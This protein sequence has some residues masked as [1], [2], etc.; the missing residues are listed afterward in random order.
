MV[1]E[2]ASPFLVFDGLDLSIYESLGSIEGELE[3]VDVEDGVYEAFDSIGRV[4][5]LKATGVKRGKFTV[6]I[7]KTHVDTVEATPTGAGRLYDL[8]R[9]HLREIGQAMPHGASL[10]HLVAKC[11]SVHEQRR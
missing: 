3:G 2:I 5:R 1:T 8:L 7:G 6:D 10:N 11:V 9:D 4:V